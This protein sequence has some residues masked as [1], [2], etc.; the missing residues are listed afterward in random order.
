M[1]EAARKKLQETAK[2]AKDRMS[3]G[4]FTKS[5]NLQGKNAIVEPGGEV[6]VRLGP[7]WT[8]AI[9]VDGKIAL[10]PDYISGD[11][12]IH[13]E[14]WEHWWEASD[15]KRTRVWC[16]RTFSVE[17]ECPICA[18]CAATLADR[19]ATDD[20]KKEAKRVSAKKA[21]IF[22]AVVGVPRKLADGKA[23]FRVLSVQD[24]VFTQISD[25]MTGGAEASFARGN[26]GDHVEGYDLKLTRPRAGGNDRWK[27]DCAPGASPLY[28]AK[29][30][31]A[32]AGWP[33]ML[34]D[35]EDVIRREMKSPL[36]LFKMYYARDPEPDEMT[37]GMAGTAEPETQSGQGETE[38]E[39]PQTETAS[40]PILDEFM[41]PSARNSS[42]SAPKT[43]PAP[44]KAAPKA[45]APRTGGRR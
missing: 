5:W 37:P 44:P 36:E 41:P 23:D 10:N 43:P 27:V 14:A 38:P 33:G 18:A 32:F 26:V 12:P 9:K 25:I 8:I 6:I 45:S 22:N 40:E 7:R 11:E 34:E 28:D 16:P 30:A 29:Q 31:A 21:Y 24:N 19:K 39:A 2:Q 3:S 4:S 20:E 15:G 17:A 1:S 13:A 35:L 42:A